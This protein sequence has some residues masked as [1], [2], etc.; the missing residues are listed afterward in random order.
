MAGTPRGRAPDRLSLR[1]DT[2]P[3]GPA[4]MVLALVIGDLH[5]PTRA[6]GIPRQFRELLVPGKVQHVLCTGD[7][8]VKEVHDFLKV[9]PPRAAAPRWGP[10][11]PGGS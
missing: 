7:L 8:C 2:A 10:P 11:P 5:I 4:A 3:A 9:S 6:A 1:P